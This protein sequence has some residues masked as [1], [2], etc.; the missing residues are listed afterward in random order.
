MVF[1]EEQYLRKFWL[2]PLLLCL[3]LLLGMI[4]LVRD[5]PDDAGIHGPMALLMVVLVMGFVLW[6][7][8][9]M[10]LETRIDEGDFVLKVHLLSTAG[11]IPMG[12][13]PVH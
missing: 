6:L 7:L 4:L 8:L 5:L 11:K 9:T 2:F 10:K 3:S 1:K 13:D 12:D